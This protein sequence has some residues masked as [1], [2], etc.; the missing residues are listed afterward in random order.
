MPIAII[1]RRLSPFP[2]EAVPDRRAS[3]TKHHGA[4][5]L[6]SVIDCTCFSTDENAAADAIGGTPNMRSSRPR[7]RRRSPDQR[8]VR[9]LVATGIRLVRLGEAYTPRPASTPAATLALPSEPARLPLPEIPTLRSLDPRS[10]PRTVPSAP[11]PAP[12]PA[13]SSS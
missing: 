12:S 13:R 4:M 5:A 7:T 10:K 3:S 6:R 1:S 11:V 8:A 9:T 2:E